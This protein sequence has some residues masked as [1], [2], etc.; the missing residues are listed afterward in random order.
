[1]SPNL[2]SI[3]MYP[4]VSFDKEEV[5]CSLLD[6]FEEDGKFNPTHWGDSE[7]VKIEYN[8]SEILEKVIFE[9]SVSEIYLHRDKSVKYTGSIDVKLTPRSFMK[10]NFHKSMPKKLWP[11]F[12]EMSDKIAEIVKPRFGVTHIFWKPI[13]PWQTDN[14]RLHIWMNLCSHPVPVKFL[15]NG[16]LGVGTR[17]YL[18]DHILEMFDREFLKNAPGSVSELNWGGMRIDVMEHPWE[19]ELTILIDNWI[20]V[21]GFLETSHVLAIPSFDEYRMGVSFSPSSAWQEYLKK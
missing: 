4:T 5:L 15:P 17:T 11:A 7:L 6:I 1:M 10:F 19:A 9:R 2:F 18:G 12:F 20:K 8:R 3:I 21:M 16:P 13:Y 14:D